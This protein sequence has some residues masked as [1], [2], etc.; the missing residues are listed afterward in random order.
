[1]KTFYPCRIAAVCA[2]EQRGMKC[3]Q[4]SYDLLRL[5]IVDKLPNLEVGAK[6]QI[7]ELVSG[8]IFHFFKQQVLDDEA[9]LFPLSKPPTPLLAVPVG[10][11]EA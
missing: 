4:F 9:L 7:A 1:M 2:E 8:T 10:N 11:V 6:V 5:G 3:L